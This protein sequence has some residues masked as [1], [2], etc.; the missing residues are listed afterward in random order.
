MTRNSSFSSSRMQVPT[1]GATAQTHGAMP[2]Q[3]S[4]Q[5][6]DGTRRAE[7]QCRLPPPRP[8]LPPPLPPPQTVVNVNETLIIPTTMDDDFVN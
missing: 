6:I 5:S 4:F 7:A 3:G 1:G 2:P 8:P